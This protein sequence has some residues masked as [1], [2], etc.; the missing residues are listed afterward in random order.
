MIVTSKHPYRKRITALSD[1]KVIGRLDLMPDGQVL[2]LIVD[3]KY[4]RLGYASRMMRVAMRH[5][6]KWL[7]AH[8]TNYF[9]K[10]GAPKAMP[11]D[12]LIEF[13][14]RCGFRVIAELPEGWRMGRS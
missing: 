1:G 10:I 2:N 13:Y 9:D 8:A 12:K 4:R 5:G 3:A 11:N 6:A 14:Q 7:T